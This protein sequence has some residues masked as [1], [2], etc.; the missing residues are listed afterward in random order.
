VDARFFAPVLIGPWAHIAFCAV[1]MVYSLRVNRLG[2][3]FTYHSKLRPKLNEELIYTY[4][5]LLFST[6]Y[7]V[8]TL[9]SYIVTTTDGIVNKPYINKQYIYKMKNVACKA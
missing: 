4:I 7:R 9:P 6:E 2:I 5:P 1:I 8:N 3:G